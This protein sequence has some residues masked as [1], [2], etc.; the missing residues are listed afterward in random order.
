MKKVYFIINVLRFWPH[1]LLLNLHP[2]KAIIKHDLDQWLIKIRIG[3]I[4]AV[5]FLMLLIYVK[6]YRNAFYLRVGIFGNI[7]SFFAPPNKQLHIDTSSQNIAS[8]IVFQ[9]GFSTIINA[10]RIGINCQIWHNVTIGQSESGTNKKPIIGNNVSIC[11]GAIII[12]DISIGDNSI[13]GAGAVV[14]KSVPSNCIVVGNPAYILRKDGIVVKH[15][16]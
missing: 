12:G 13:V 11:A 9:H 6:E 16:L 15:A 7:L 1:L 8:G 5:G 4:G 14:T 3:Q 2:K 10:L